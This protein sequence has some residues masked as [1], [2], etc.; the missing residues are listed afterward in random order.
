[1][2][3]DVAHLGFLLGTW[4]GGG[5]GGFPTISDFTFGEEIV[6][7]DADDAWLA[8]RQ[9]SWADDGSVLHWERGFLRPGSEP[10]TVELVLAHPLGLTEVAEGRVEGTTLEIATA[11]GGVGR[12]RTGSDVT[13]LRRRYV[14]DGDE[15]RYDL[16]MATD[17]TPLAWHLSSVLRREGSG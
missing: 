17:A 15:L 11:P 14:V 3:P 8:I 12:T 9:R 6:V 13:E 16:E 1:V 2:H 7:E 10:A 5:R 4:T